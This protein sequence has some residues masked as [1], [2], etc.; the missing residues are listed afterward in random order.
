M[1]ETSFDESMLDGQDL[2]VHCPDE[3][4]ADE[5]MK[6]LEKH[7]IRWYGD[8]GLPTEDSRWDEF[9]GETCYWVED[10]KITYGDVDD[11]Q[12]RR[13]Y[14]H[15]KTTFFGVKTPDFD[16]ATDDEIRSLLGV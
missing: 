1:W 12:S 8:N 2:I 3:S 4:L 9:S 10:G 6:I 14:G 5:L 13:Y 16:T 15:T 11:A 7:G